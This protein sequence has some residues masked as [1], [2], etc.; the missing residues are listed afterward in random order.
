MARRCVEIGTNFPYEAKHNFQADAALQGSNSYISLRQR[1][2]GKI[3]KYSGDCSQ[4]QVS[5]SMRAKVATNKGGC[6]WAI[7]NQA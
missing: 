3:V 7:F 6:Q 1:D 2:R 4:V 5:N